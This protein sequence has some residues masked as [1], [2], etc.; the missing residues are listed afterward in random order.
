V[1]GV[2]RVLF[3]RVQDRDCE[4]RPPSCLTSS[5]GVD[6]FFPPCPRLSPPVSGLRPSP[7]NG[8]LLIVVARHFPGLPLRK[9]ECVG[10]NCLN[11]TLDAV[12]PFV[13]PSSAFRST[14]FYYWLSL[15][16]RKSRRAHRKKV[17]PFSLGFPSVTDRDRTY[18]GFSEVL[19]W[20][21]SITLLSHPRILFFWAPVAELFGSRTE[22]VCDRLSD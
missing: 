10:G 4:P 16:D 11:L 17:I 14:S 12:F 18:V 9:P 3:S 20:S 8:S 22:K 6:N 5:V 15:A 7:T 19:V 21:V 13:S 2:R 1:S